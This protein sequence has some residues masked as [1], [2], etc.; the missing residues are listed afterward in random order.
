MNKKITA[1]INSFR[2]IICVLVTFALVLSSVTI[3][4]APDAI[5]YDADDEQSSF[6]LFEQLGI[7]P[8]YIDDSVFEKEIS[9][10]EFITYIA[11]M[12]KIDEYDTIT[13]QYFRD[14]QSDNF[15]YGSVNNLC[16]MGIIKQGN[17]FFEPDRNITHD[18]VITIF[19]RMLGYGDISEADGGFPNG[20]RKIGNR[21]KIMPINN[22]GKITLRNVMTA[23]KNVMLAPVYEPA[24][25]NSKTMYYN[26]GDTTLFEIYW[27]IKYTEGIVEGIFGTGLY[28]V[29]DVKENECIINGE[30]FVVSDY[31]MDDYIGLSVEAI[32][33]QEN[34]SSDKEILYVTAIGNTVTEIK[35][36]DIRSVNGNYTINYTDENKIKEINIK[37]DAPIILNGTRLD[38]DIISNMNPG[39]GTVRFID[40]DGVGG[41][42]V[43]IYRVPQLIRVSYKDKDKKL[44]F[45]SYDKTSIGCNENDYKRIDYKMLSTGDKVSFDNIVRNNVLSIYKS[46]DCLEIIICDKTEAGVVEARTEQDSKIMLK[47]NG[48][49]YLVSPLFKNS[50]G[51]DS[52][53]LS[54]GHSGVFILDEYGMITG[55]A[56]GMRDGMQLGFVIKMAQD[57]NPFDKR[58]KFKIFESSGAIAEIKTAEKWSINGTDIKDCEISGTP[59]MKSNGD[60]AP[61]FLYYKCNSNGDLTAFETAKNE[62]DTNKD[63]DLVMTNNY[64]DRNYAYNAMMFDKRVII[65]TSTVCFVVPKDEDIPNAADSDFAIVNYR[66]FDDWESYNIGTFKTNPESPVEQFLVCRSLNES[67][68]NS[69]SAAI[70]VD[71]IGTCMNDD[72][73]VVEYVKGYSMGSAATLMAESGFSFA[74][75]NIRQGDLIRVGTNSQNYVKEVQLLYRYGNDSFESIVPSPNFNSNYQYWIGY[76]YDN[77]EGVVKIGSKTWE[78]YDF[79]GDLRS[80]S[81]MVYDPTR[82]NDKVYIGDIDDV[83]S[84]KKSGTKGDKIII[85]TN[86][87]WVKCAVVYKEAS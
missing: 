71:E 64:E 56:S 52:D 16:R 74:S 54:V 31:T 36:E 76:A 40:N 10:S 72:G 21:L 66:F 65:G 42:D 15:A 43:A 63:G 39:V 25:F 30:K 6:G 79:I 2:N 17:G 75:Q 13:P 26:E 27:N 58:I 86:H 4:G 87:G 50:V 12:L 18:E 83:K 38:S 35:C 70:L 1:F 20:Y 22:T 32:Y 53:I 33:R 11:R 14:V 8:H 61:Q 46:R 51:K 57:D 62:S 44:I 85:R 41:Y 68:A 67:E 49:D 60:F 45:N 3:L 80:V 84:F 28:S 59:L 73:I 23:A 34:S 29:T 7:I 48:T 24:A 78:N 82:K 81:I 55:E 37:P 5:K 69:S 9:R 19:V 77:T 47:V